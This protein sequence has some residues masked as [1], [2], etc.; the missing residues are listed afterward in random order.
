MKIHLIGGKAQSRF[1]N[2]ESGDEV[3]TLNNCWFAWARHRT[4]RHFNIHKYENLVRYNFD[5]KTTVAF[6]EAHPKIAFYSTD[7]WPEL[8][9]RKNAYVFPRDALATLPG[10]ADYHCGSFDWMA[11]YAALLIDQEP[12]LPGPHEIVVHGV[13]LLIEA[14]EPIS[15]RACLEY[16]LGVAEGMG[17]KVTVTPDCDLFA[18][19][20]L[21]KSN[22]VYGYDDT[23][24]YEDR[25]RP[26]DGE[27]PYKI[28][29]AA[30]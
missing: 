10:R 21:V 14:G 19:Y 22:M 18:F 29:D 2:P 13:S 15:A 7:E 12:V 24:I 30:E 6:L 17:I 23:P 26:A 20:H 3:W 9:D 28:A 16:W 27:P 8:K 11:A 1:F 25:T 5:I 4:T